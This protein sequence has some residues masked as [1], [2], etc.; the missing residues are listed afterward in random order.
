MKKILYIQNAIF[1]L[2]EDFTGGIT[3]ALI[4]FCKYFTE[5]S[6]EVKIGEVVEDNL[7]YLEGKKDKFSGTMA[8]SINKDGTWVNKNIIKDEDNN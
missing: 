7:E 4:E 3:E 1:E 2:P 8:L 5:K 6:K